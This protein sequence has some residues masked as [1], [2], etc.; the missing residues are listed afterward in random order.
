MAPAI[1]AVKAG[2]ARGPSA[3]STQ[4]A[5]KNASHRIQPAQISASATNKNS[6]CVLLTASDQRRSPDAA[7]AEAPPKRGISAGVRED[8]VS[9]AVPKMRRSLRSSYSIAV[10]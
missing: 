10:G 2:D 5:R 9:H 3:T 7:P 8:H 6:P 4:A 1:S